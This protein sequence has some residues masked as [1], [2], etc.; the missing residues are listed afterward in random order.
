MGKV[1][2]GM[3]LAFGLVFFIGVVAV[4]SPSDSANNP[5]N[6]ASAYTV[7]ESMQVSAL[8]LWSDYQANEVAADN[9]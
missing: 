3:F 5:P 2:L 6:T 1:I 4:H 9:V 7:S 8:K